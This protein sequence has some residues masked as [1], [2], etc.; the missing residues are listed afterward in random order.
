MHAL[1]TDKIYFSTSKEARSR[2]KRRGELMNQ[3]QLSFDIK[4]GWMSGVRMDAPITKK[5]L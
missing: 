3:T 4:K 2:M 5:S 1:K